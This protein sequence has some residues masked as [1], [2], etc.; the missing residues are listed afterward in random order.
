[1]SSDIV[2]LPLPASSLSLRPLPNP[3]TLVNAQPVGFPVQLDHVSAAPAVRPARPLKMARPDHWP[4]P[5]K[6]P[7][8]AVHLP[9]I[10][11]FIEI[12][13]A[14][15]ALPESLTAGV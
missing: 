15:P 8:L 9:G 11:F 13:S 1:M 6:S 3:E 10:G 12:V 2:L 4:Q 5:A 14:S 7:T